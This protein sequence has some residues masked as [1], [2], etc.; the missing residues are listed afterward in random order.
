MAIRASSAAQITALVADLASASAVTRD[1]AVARLTVIGARAVDRLSAA[2]MVGTPDA[3]TAALRALEGIGDPR[4]LA[5]AV[6]ALRAP[7]TAP[8]AV[9]VLRR[10]FRGPNEPDAIG[11]LTAV[12]LD[13][14]RP[15]PIR[16]AAAEALGDLGPA[17]LTPLWAQ[18]ETDADETVREWAAGRGQPA[19]RPVKAPGPAVDGE[20]PLPDDP[21]SARRAV[22]RE[23][24]TM[25]LAAMRR[26]VETLKEREEAA[27]PRQ[28]PEWAAARA[29]AHAAL[30]ARGS[31][32][33]LYDL[34]DSIAAAA[35]PLPVAFLAAVA[36]IGDA[37]CLEPLAIA[38]A[39]STGSGEQ[40]WREHL[41]R[42][43]HTIVLR[44]RIAPRHAAMK[45]VVARWPAIV[46]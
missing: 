33:A 6:A 39:R 18:L 32:V 21:A 5:P 16:L 20:R 9:A 13:T 29:A 19:R 14:G 30:A 36:Q 2:A 24:A 42:A 8:A 23:G 35:A 28:R 46:R 1:A 3:R 27:P 25:P 15:A 12:A 37:S 38:Y 10:L 17:A 11:A 22:A 4:A 34:R 45:K 44:D 26:L 43:F 7:D 41:R 40:W 31:R